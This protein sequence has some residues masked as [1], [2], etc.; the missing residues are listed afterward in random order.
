MY[1]LHAFP[2]DAIAGPA[3]RCPMISSTSEEIITGPPPG[4]PTPPPFGP[5]R[6]SGKSDTPLARMHFDIEN[7]TF[8][9]PKG[10]FG[11]W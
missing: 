1:S 10:Y 4:Q 8:G 2:A 3:N 9:A 7:G 5:E 6:G 11:L